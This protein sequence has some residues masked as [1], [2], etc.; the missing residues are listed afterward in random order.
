[1]LLY[2]VKFTHKETGKVA[3]KR[4]ISKYGAKRV[5]AERYGDEQYD[6]FKIELLESFQYS[7]DNYSIARAV[8]NTVEQVLNGLVPPKRS[9]YSIEEHFGDPNGS[10][11]NFSGVTEFIVDY[12]E[13]T[14]V[15]TFKKATKNLWKI[16]V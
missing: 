7:H 6:Q 15:S 9:D 16:K 8:L 13:K 3:Y 12:D 14:V 10:Y 5:I 2:L 1:M 11:G 4:G